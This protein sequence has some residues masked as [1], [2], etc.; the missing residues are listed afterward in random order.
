M[1]DDLAPKEI[2]PIKGTKG[3]SQTNTK[4]HTMVA[5][6]VERVYLRKIPRKLATQISAE[7]IAQETCMRIF[8]KGFDEAEINSKV[9]L[10]I[11][12]RAMI[13]KLRQCTAKKRMPENGSILNE[14]GA[15]SVNIMPNVA[16]GVGTPS[17]FEIKRELMDQVWRTAQGIL[18][19]DEFEIFELK[20]AHYLTD[21]EV[22][23]LLD[24][25]K[26][27]IRSLDYRIRKKMAESLGELS[28]FSSRIQ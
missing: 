7:D 6:L 4:I 23:K 19:P 16:G 3:E 27:S 1:D 8:T 11:A 13:D 20:H 9:V 25:S 12:R 5:K 14:P 21:D 18:T 10:T 2:P 15:S 22:A 24:K 26:S 17:S 28:D